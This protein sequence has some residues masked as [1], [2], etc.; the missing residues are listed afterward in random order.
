MWNIPRGTCTHISGIDMDK[1]K[2]VRRRFKRV[3][4]FSFCLFLFLC[5]TKQQII[6]TFTFL[7]VDSSSIQ[8]CNFHSYSPNKNIEMGIL[9]ALDVTLNHLFNQF[10]E[11]ID[12]NFV[13]NVYFSS[14]SY[15][16]TKIPLHLQQNSHS[17][18]P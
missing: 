6:F 3:L 17:H 5:I 15:Q 4:R 8:S 2:G 10:V 7:K 18:K 12:L 9:Y 1:W 14:S 13:T 11:I 16:S